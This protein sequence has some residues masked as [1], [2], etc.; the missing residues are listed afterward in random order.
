MRK[1][2]VTFPSLVL[3]LEGNHVTDK[4]R[5]GVI[6][7]LGVRRLIPDEVL[8]QFL[9]ACELDNQVQVVQLGEITVVGGGVDILLFGKQKARSLPIDVSHR[10]DFGL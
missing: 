2:Q 6:Q 8:K 7:H 4:P 5:N 3:P 10:N 9:F 1:I